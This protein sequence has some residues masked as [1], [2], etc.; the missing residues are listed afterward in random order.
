MDT[1]VVIVSWNVKDLLRENLQALFRSRGDIVFEVFVVDNNSEDGTV[2]MLRKEF[3]EVKVIAN[4]DNLG[5]AKANNMAIERAKGRYILLLNPDM[6]VLPDTLGNMVSWMD[7]R[8]EA[9]V[10][11]C[12]LVTENGDIVPHVR[13]FPTVWD[14]AAVTVKI[15]HIFPGILN[16]YI[17]ANF[18]YET[19]Q[20]VDTIRGSFFMIRKE[21]L[22]ELGGLDERYFIWFEEV[23]Y[24]KKAKQAGWKVM[25]TPTA[26]CMDYVGKSFV[27]VPRGKTQ[28]Y[29]RD[30]MLKYFYKWHPAWQYWVLKILWIPSMIISRLKMK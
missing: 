9:G 26:K 12:K 19:E 14:Q 22:E 11:G 21:A 15:P 30:S 7:S 5:F 2:E 3:P 4:K 23:D 28:K 29:F 20:E 16:K 8:P 18:D 1:S 24:C 6:K 27:Q 13:R 25:Y 10:A 17:S